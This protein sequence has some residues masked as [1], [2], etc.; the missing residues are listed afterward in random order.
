MDTHNHN[1]MNLFNQL[2]LKS[3]EEAI[4]EFITLHPLGDNILLVNAPF[5]SDAQRHFLSESLQTD[6]DWTEIIDQLDAQ[7]RANYRR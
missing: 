1:M 3:D 7:L 5:W 4:T 2:G 6:G